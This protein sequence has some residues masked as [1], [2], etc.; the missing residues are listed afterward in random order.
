MKQWE[1]IRRQAR[2]WHTRMRA[3]ASGDAATELLKAAASETGVRCVAV[4]PS[5]PTLS[6]AAAV[7]DPEYARIWFN[8][9]VEPN[10]AGYYQAH[11][12]AHFWL[13][14]AAANCQD[15]D[16][17]G[18]ASEERVPLG[19]QRVEG[20]G[21]RE[22]R[23][24]QANVFAREFLLPADKLR[25]W[26]I[27]DGLK[28]TDIAK[29]VGV[30]ES[31]VRYQLAE[32]LLIAPLRDTGP[33]DPEKPVAVSAEPDLDASQQA[34]AHAERGPILVDAGPGTGKTK[35]LVGRV[36]YLLT[37]RHIPPIAIL[38][39]TFSNKAAEE[40]RER[41]ARVAPEAAP[42]IWMGTFHAF[43]LELLRKYGDRIGLPADPVI[44][45]PTDAIALL[46]RLLP[47]LQLH[48]YRYLPE[49]TR[50]LRDL[51][52]AISRAKDELAGPEQ[53]LTLAQAMRNEAV[54]VDEV[55]AAEKAL[56]VARVYSI[57]QAELDAAQ[58]LDFS[59][60]IWKSV[61]LLQSHPDVYMLTQQTYQHV[62][63]DEYQDVNRASGVLLKELV[64]AGEDLWA[65]GDT[66]QSIYRFRGAAPRNV[67]NFEIDFP[68]AHVISLERNYRSQPNI[69]AAFAALAPR[70]QASAGRPFTPWDAD[71]ASE[72]GTVYLE[73]A[74]NLEAEAQ[75]LAAEIGRQR[76]NGISYRNQAVLCRSHTSLAR[77]A[78]Q[79]EKSGIPV[80]YLGDIFERPEVRDL[81]ALVSLA[82]EPNGQGLL[83]VAGFPE[84]AV[85]QADILALLRL[86]RDR[87]M[88]FP[89]ALALAIEDSDISEAGRVGLA[90]L[91]Q[92]LDGIVYST[93]AA[94]FLSQYLFECST[95]L[96][97]VL[98]DDTL[99]GQQHRM[100][101]YQFLQF[102]HE[103]T[104][105]T[106]ETGLDQ[107]RR[108]LADI[109]RLEIFG[110][111]KQL[112]QAPAWADRLDAV[113]L[114]T[115]HASKGLEFSVVYL[116]ILG[117]R[118]L[119]AGRRH[120]YCP[121]PL[122]LIPLEADEHDEE[123]ECLFFV[124]LSRARDVLV[125]SRAKRYGAQSSNASKLLHQIASALPRSPE[126]EITWPSSEPE[127]TE[128]EPSAPLPA[129]LPEYEGSE[130][131]QYVYCPH[132]YYAE[133][134]LGL[135]G[136]RDDSAY[137]QFHRSVYAVL[138][139]MAAEQAS[140]RGVE[141]AAAQ[142]QLAEVWAERGPLDHPY[143]SIY[144]ESASEMVARAVAARTESYK[145]LPREPFAIP[146]EHGRVI[147]TPDHIEQ[148]ENGSVVFLRQRT[149]RISTDE[150]GKDIYAL[151]QWAATKHKG[152]VEIVS[153]SSDVRE[154]VKLSSTV[155]DKRL[156]AY[157]AA[158]AGIQAG[159]FTPKP[160]E[161]ECPR[162]PFYFICPIP[163]Q[164]PTSQ[165]S[166][167]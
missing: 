80:L 147:F 59:D 145:P 144:R 137:I 138:S 119:P 58:Q 71:R 155:L 106:T 65:V 70:M 134:I 62:L 32:A 89:A 121:P 77:L 74:A 46:E 115:I 130:L 43:G 57:Y 113:R 165:P 135:S 17:N 84:Y 94:T 61:R 150:K 78:T 88:P 92:H 75:G 72:G 68:G 52:G 34:A 131:D 83:R 154:P 56:E 151:Y 105:T 55:E 132:Q 66:R 36:Q 30:S 140:G 60:L 142:Q 69:V 101:L 136:R 167:P 133:H 158:M 81:L 166:T 53:Y 5:D 157:D 4:A 48:H 153:L 11:E 141:A 85:P 117:Q 28:A 45:D 39:L 12:Y 67:R 112:R 82:C 104:R 160:T 9:D 21:P 54:N 93:G 76:A 148:H 47:T 10:L 96:Q 108:F 109:R 1:E 7:L 6:G 41:V 19:V 91:A 139:W 146:L 161:F 114:M 99:T 35:T 159:V 38:A 50:H 79:L 15:A 14:G 13:D 40:M 29:R 110:E 162:C 24:C 20:Y 90:R 163:L 123:E 49:P 18:E 51:L 128:A 3:V 103:Q 42:S 122:G 118:Y 98:T 86:A 25:Q 120:N 73:V 2:L 125:L 26:F 95:Y 23:E 64:G 87:R 107:K 156:K 44:L 127:V 164:L 100:A 8:R 152:A 33:D 97:Q 31:L 126:S 16:I 111:E 27:R 143:E 124:A 37:E 22:R 129:E 102:A 149:G 116:P 63:V